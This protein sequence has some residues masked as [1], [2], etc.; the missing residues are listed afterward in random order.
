MNQVPVKLG[1]LALLLTV[2]SICL[3]TLSIL[4][5]TTSRADASLAG[6]YA[7]TVTA[8]YQLMN[9]G[10]EFLRDARD[11]AGQGMPVS[12]IPG[13]VPGPDGSLSYELEEDGM[14]L[15]IAI[16]ASGGEVEILEYRV[17][18]DWAEDTSPGNLWMGF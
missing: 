13:T 5:F 4:T 14:K 8:R 16:K 15:D 2:I 1:P 7:Q 12:S 11:L 17:I 6:K 3:T 18:K 10:E 9:L